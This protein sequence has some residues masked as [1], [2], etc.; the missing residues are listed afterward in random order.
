[1]R[2]NQKKIILALDTLDGKV[3]VKVG[4]SP[5]DQAEGCSEGH[6]GP[7]LGGVLHTNVNVEGKAKG[8]DIEETKNFLHVPPRCHHLRWGH[9][10]DDLA[11]LE[12]IGARSVIVGMA[13]YLG[14]IKPE[15]VWGREHEEEK[16][17]PGP[18]RRKSPCASSWRKRHKRR[19]SDD[20]FLRHMLETLTVMHLST[21]SSRPP[22]TTPIT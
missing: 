8:I 10:P 5:Q 6:G 21:S 18:R 7:P 2:S 1:M 9:H 11:V 3:Q 19:R 22:G 4:R 14:T 13:L 15:Q 16:L 20:Q 12:D 17:T